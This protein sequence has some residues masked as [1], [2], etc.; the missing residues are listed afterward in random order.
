MSTSF[1]ATGAQIN[2]LGKANIH[3]IIQADTTMK[4]ND[5]LVPLI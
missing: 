4:G 5:D 2:T 1:W 3:A